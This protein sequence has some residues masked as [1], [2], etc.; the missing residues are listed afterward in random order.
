MVGDR[1]RDQAG[2]PRNARGRDSAGRPLPRGEVGV[3][4]IPDDPHLTVAEGLAL[5]QR[6]LDDD[7]PFG[8]HEV[9]EALWKQTADPDERLVWRGLAQL[10]VGLTHLQRGNDT[11]GRTLLERG[12]VTLSEAQQHT[13]VD[14][15]PWIRWSTD[16]ATA[17]S[18][19]H[20]PPAPPRLAQR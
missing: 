9:L 17:V 16:A 6:L 15:V 3:S 11:G 4:P 2:R 8:A 20:Q 7:R 5:A 18:G 10:M 12:S 13:A 14:V 19:R 1:D